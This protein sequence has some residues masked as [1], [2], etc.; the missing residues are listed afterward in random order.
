[1]VAA[2]LPS[3]ALIV[4]AVPGPYGRV[5]FAFLARQGVSGLR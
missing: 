3:R 2:P 5:D 4:N 1:M